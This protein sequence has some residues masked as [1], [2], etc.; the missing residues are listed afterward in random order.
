MDT[1]VLYRLDRVGNL[2]QL[3]SGF[4]GV[5]MRAISG[6]FHQAL[7]SKKISQPG[8]LD[9]VFRRQNRADHIGLRRGVNFVQM[10]LRFAELHK[11]L[12]TLVEGA[13]TDHVGTRAERDANALL[14]E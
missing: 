10:T 4:L 3:A 5:G 1:T 14:V 7:F 9:D 6:K 13:F 2:D 11:V 8:Q 12:D